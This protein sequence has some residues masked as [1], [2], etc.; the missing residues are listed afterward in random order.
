[1]AYYRCDDCDKDFPEDEIDDMPGED[2]CPHCEGPVIWWAE[3]G[4]D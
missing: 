1:M 2:E 4:E 3:A